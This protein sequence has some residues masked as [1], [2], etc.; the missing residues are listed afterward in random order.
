M[1]VDVRVKI[2]AKPFIMSPDMQMIEQLYQRGQI[3]D[4]VYSEMM[5]ELY[6][7]PVEPVNA[8]QVK[9]DEAKAGLI[10][11]EE[12][13][14]IKSKYSKKDGKGGGGGGGS[15]SGGGGGGKNVFR[16]F[17]KSKFGSGAGG[18]SGGGGG[19]NATK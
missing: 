11:M 7:F 6:G 10:V 2:I 4:D 5:T 13:E 16:E 3:K 8:M 19:G 14:R 12:Q 18:S 1:F 17:E 15:S 9:I